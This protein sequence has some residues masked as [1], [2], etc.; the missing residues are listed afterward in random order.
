MDVWMILR[1]VGV[2]AISLLCVIGTVTF[3][4]AFLAVIATIQQMCRS[5]RLEKKETVYL[6]PAKKSDIAPFNHFYAGL[7]LDLLEHADE[8]QKK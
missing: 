2:F 8:I 1:I 4:I 7:Y 3:M 5:K 6:P